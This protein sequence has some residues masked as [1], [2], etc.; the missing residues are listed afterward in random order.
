MY[1]TNTPCK[2]C[3]KSHSCDAKDEGN[4]YKAEK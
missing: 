4:K 2:V 1:A 3:H